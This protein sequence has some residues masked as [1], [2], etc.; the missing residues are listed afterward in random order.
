MVKFGRQ[1]HR[2]LTRR[3]ARSQP[4]LTLCTRSATQLEE[5]RNPEWEEGYVN[6]SALKKTLKEMITSGH[7]QVFDENS[8]Y[9][10]ISVATS[11]FRVRTPPQPA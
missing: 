10:P 8:V 1:V 6:Y 7:C 9:A 11:A 2:P 4:A 5:Y 3:S